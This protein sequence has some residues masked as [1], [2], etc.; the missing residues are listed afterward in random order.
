MNS[1]TVKVLVLSF[2]K[3]SRDPRVLKQIETL[4]KKFEVTTIG[5]D[6]AGVNNVRHYNVIKE[7][8]KYTIHN[9][10]L[11]FRL[12]QIYTSKLR[13]NVE[14]IEILKGQRF[15]VI[16][17]NDIETLPVATKISGGT[18]KIILDAH[19]YSP[20]QFEERLYWKI[21]F[22]DYTDWV[23][24]KYLNKVDAMFTVSP[25]ISKEYEKNYNIGSDLLLNL[26][27]KENLEPRIYE[28]KE[29]ITIVHHGILNKSR[30]LDAMVRAIH[31]LGDKYQLYLYLVHQGKDYQ[32]KLISEWKNLSNVHI[33]EPVPMKDIS[34]ELNQY[35]IGLFFLPPVNF[36]YRYALPNK[37]F[38]FIQARLAVVIGPSVEMANI[39]RNHKCGFVTDDFTEESLKST[40]RTIDRKKIN[41]CK[42][43]SHNIANLYQYDVNKNK[44]IEVVNKL[45]EN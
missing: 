10:L 32:Q 35:D 26:P 25:Q 40:I 30:G 9:G 1:K 5:L 33:K 37:L 19:E 17:A 6:D 3:L 20:R 13:Q 39:V 42:I 22:R 34:K 11:L 7:G 24:K 4:S 44:L 8:G 28:N 36:N 45:V 43:N 2:T 18:S 12:Y 27:Y 31:E 23:C 41:T 14:T 29:K 16:I 15:D 38:E 21:L